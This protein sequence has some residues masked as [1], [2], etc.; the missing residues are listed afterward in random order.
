M[1]TVNREGFIR[2]KLNSSDHKHRKQT[3]EQKTLDLLLIAVVTVCKKR[4]GRK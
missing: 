1:T 4:N 3:N 2:A